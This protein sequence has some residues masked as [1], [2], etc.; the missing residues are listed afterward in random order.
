MSTPRCVRR[1]IVDCLGKPVADTGLNFGDGTVSAIALLVFLA[2][3][4][5]AASTPPA[6]RVAVETA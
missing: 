6:A 4:A 3:V 2:L 5:Y 1:A